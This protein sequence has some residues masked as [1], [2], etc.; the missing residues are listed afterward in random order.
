LQMLNPQMASAQGAAT[1]AMVSLDIYKSFN[2]INRMLKK[3]NLFKP[4][5]DNKA[6]YDKLY[7]HYQALYKNNK[8]AFKKLNH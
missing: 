1:I 2:E 7:K 8:A 4:N 6:V 5:P 3:N